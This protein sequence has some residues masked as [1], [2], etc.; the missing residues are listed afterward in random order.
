MQAVETSRRNEARH[1]I[2]AA[3]DQ[4]TAHSRAPKR[5]SD[6]AWRNVP[7]LRGQRDD[8]DAGRRRSAS[9]AFRRDQQ[10]ANAIIGEQPRVRAE[11][12]LR[13]DHGPCG[14]RAGNLPDRQLRI[15]GDRRADTN[16][17]DIDQ[18]TQAVQVLDSRRTI[19]VFGMSGRRR[20]PAIKRL[21]ELSDNNEI[22]DCSIPQRSEQVSPKA[23]AAA[24]A[25]LYEKARQSC[26]MR[27]EAPT[28]GMGKLP[29]CTEKIEFEGFA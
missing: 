13:I 27:R 17:D 10:A 21:P 28:C 19:D 1:R 18:R 29:G 9:R 20:H 26:P 3:F 7:V 12:S 11:A 5:R 25:V 22:V 2:G 23:L 15:V 6:V 16:D 24:V 14:L 4:D 8:F